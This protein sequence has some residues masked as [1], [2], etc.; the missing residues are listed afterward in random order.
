M[1]QWVAGSSKC[2]SE[3]LTNADDCRL[4]RCADIM[5]GGEGPLPRCK[6]FKYCYE[7]EIVMYAYFKKL[8]YFSTE[9]TYSLFAARGC[10]AFRGGRPLAF[11][12]ATMPGASAAKRKRVWPATRSEA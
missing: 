9:C 5:T 11:I 1:T 7:K 2:V 4:S 3:M 12:P 10:A 6:P 8:D